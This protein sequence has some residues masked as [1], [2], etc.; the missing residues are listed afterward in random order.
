MNRTPDPNSR[1]KL[2][3]RTR[4]PDQAR[5]PNPEP[6]PEPA[7]PI[8]E[9]LA[10]PAQNKDRMV[11]SVENSQN[12]PCSSAAE[13]AKG[14]SVQIEFAGRSTRQRRHSPT[15]ARGASIPNRVLRTLHAPAPPPFLLYS[16]DAPRENSERVVHSKQNLVMFHSPA[17]RRKPREGRR[18]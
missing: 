8:P 14:S 5:E 9:S 10:L 18:F 7:S 16:Q 1:P 12:I 13:N 15:T 17:A 3:P 6:N 4:S 2:G 11:N